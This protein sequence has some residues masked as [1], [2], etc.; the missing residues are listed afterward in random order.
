MIQKNLSHSIL[1]KQKHFH[2]VLTMTLN[3]YL[4]THPDR[5]ASSVLPTD[6]V[7][8]ERDGVSK[9]A[10][11]GALK[12]QA[13]RRF[14][15][16]FGYQ[17]TPAGNVSVAYG[18]S[19]K[20]VALAPIYGFRIV[21]A[22]VSA[23]ATVITS[24][25]SPASS[26]TGTG[27]MSAPIIPTVDGIA[28]TSKA[29]IAGTDS[30]PSYLVSDFIS[31]IGDA[32]T[33][34]E[35]RTNIA[36]AANNKYLSHSPGTGD[37]LQSGFTAKYACESS[38]TVGGTGD[39]ITTNPSVVYAAGDADNVSGFA[40]VQFVYKSACASMLGFGDSIMKGE[41]GAE[42]SKGK[43]APL[44]LASQLDPRLSALAFGIGGRATS[45]SHL[46]ALNTCKQLRPDYCW[47]PPWSPNDGIASAQWQASL[48][49]AM[50]I[51]DE[52]AKYGVTAVF[53]TPNP[54]NYATS[55]LTQWQALRAEV[56]ALCSENDIP[57]IDISTA[58][59]DPANL[60][61]MKA[62]YF[63]TGNASD[64]LHPNPLGKVAESHAIIAC[65]KP[66]LDTL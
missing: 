41:A 51:R 34:I 14:S 2:K 48:G 54:W 37:T 40:S 3:E 47:I 13:Q 42:T 32:G 44:M 1:A 12:K 60:G 11:A 35:V 29:L 10:S 8:V 36:S 27:T 24:K 33:I 20:F 26:L 66:I 6:L 43:Y 31:N 62:E 46:V 59:E 28:V 61:S 21:W 4:T 55:N 25:C 22:N 56:I 15:A 58:L 18:F 63:G 17:G 53:S 30:V 19:E 64:R 39:V 23:N 49:R 52:L 16:P 57:L 38:G 5:L 50:I 9:V 65:M 45:V 7:Q